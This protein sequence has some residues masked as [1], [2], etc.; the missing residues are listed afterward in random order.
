MWTRR[1][2]LAA[3]GASGA[4]VALGGWL[5]ACAGSQVGR[6]SSTQSTSLDDVLPQILAIIEGRVE[7]AFVWSRR[8]RRHRASKDSDEQHF[9]LSHSES[10]VFGGKGRTHTLTN[11]TREELLAGAEAFAA[12]IPTKKREG[13]PWRVPTLETLETTLKID[14]AS[15]DSKAFLEPVRKL[16]TQAQEH[17]GSRIIYRNSYLLADDVETRFVS[18][19]RNQRRRE[20]RLRSGV[21]FAAWTGDDVV[22]S[23]AERAAV[24]GLELSGP[25]PRELRQGAESALARVHARSAPTGLQDVILSPH[26]AGLVAMQAI[27]KPA[28]RMGPRPAPEGPLRVTNDPGRKHGYGSYLRDARGDE[29]KALSFFGGQ[30]LA[31]MREGNMR[32]DAGLNLRAMPANVVVAAGTS[33]EQDLVAD[34]KAGVY[35]DDPLHCSVDSQGKTLALLCGRARE[36]RD[37]HFTGRL[38][39]RVLASASC[40]AFIAET[41]AL[42]KTLYSQAFEEDSVPMS[43]RSPAWLSR[44]RVEAG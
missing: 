26:C 43:A 9:D 2:L 36:I 5:S 25:S 3:L 23:V 38:F 31:K 41:R 28:F 30:P 12:A 1:E 4:S 6:E 32:R 13:A 39:P 35:L 34:V 14:P 17:G 8:S 33:S 27:A 29:P 16:F 10:V 42:G 7:N 20:V 11:A 15:Q 24:G 22:S 40:D 18:R 37:G 21:L 19:A 44:A